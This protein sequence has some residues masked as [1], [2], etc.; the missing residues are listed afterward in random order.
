MPIIIQV[1][2]IYLAIIFLF[3]IKK[4]RIIKD[5]LDKKGFAASTLI[6]IAPTLQ[7]FALYILDK[8]LD[9]YHQPELKYTLWLIFLIKKQIPTIRQI[10]S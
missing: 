8:K 4:G 1:L 3:A 9:I 2:D 6:F 5:I 10:S 7:F